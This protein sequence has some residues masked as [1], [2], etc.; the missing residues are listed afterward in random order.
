MSKWR[1]KVRVVEVSYDDWIDEYEVVAKD[2]IQARDL[3]VTHLN[4]NPPLW[5]SIRVRD[6]SVTDP[7]PS[8]VVSKK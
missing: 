2:N 5:K 3:I 6:T 7:G 8:R 4:E 1:M